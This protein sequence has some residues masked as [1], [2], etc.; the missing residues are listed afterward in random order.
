MSG[1]TKTGVYV[2]VTLHFHFLSTRKRMQYYKSE[3]SSFEF[4]G[5]NLWSFRMIEETFKL[6]LSICNGK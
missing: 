3:N 4:L 1:M 2:T 6:W 5:G